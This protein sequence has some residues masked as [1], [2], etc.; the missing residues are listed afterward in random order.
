MPTA[1][2]SI[3]LLVAPF[4]KICPAPS[5]ALPARVVTNCPVVAILPLTVR[6]LYIPPVA[7]ILAL[8]LI[9]AVVINPVELIAPPLITAPLILPLTFKLAPT[10]ALPNTLPVKLA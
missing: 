8:E 3:R 1:A 5:A 2:Q 10:K 6:R 7:I 4:R 9:P